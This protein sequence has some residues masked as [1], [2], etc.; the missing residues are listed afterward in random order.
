MITV[1]EGLND[2][3]WDL[4]P[5]TSKQ[6]SGMKISDVITTDRVK[7]KQDDAA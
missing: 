1:E 2:W 5:S 3:H 7:S 6:L 4:P